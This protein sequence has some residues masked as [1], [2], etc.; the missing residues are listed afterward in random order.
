V[1]SAV[2]TYTQAGLASAL[3]LGDNVNRLKLALEFT[4]NAPLP[5]C[6]DIESEWCQAYGYDRCGNRKVDAR[7]GLKQSI[8]VTG[9]NWGYIDDGGNLTAMPFGAGVETFAYDAEDR[10]VKQTAGGVDTVYVYDAMGVS[11]FR[12]QATQSRYC[13]LGIA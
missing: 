5:A 1:T 8:R 6:S 10:R 4:T 12:G 9:A 3:T 2:Y 13:A 7:W 11:G